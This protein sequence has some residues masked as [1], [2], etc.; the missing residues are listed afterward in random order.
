MINLCSDTI[1]FPFCRWENLGLLVRFL[2]VVSFQVRLMKDRDTGENKGYA[3]VAFKTK[4]VAQK[5]IE[6]IHSREFKVL[7]CSIKVSLSIFCFQDI[8]QLR[9]QCW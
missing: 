6:E 4:E 8:F 3:F 1:N 2:F 9:I 5:A 7:R